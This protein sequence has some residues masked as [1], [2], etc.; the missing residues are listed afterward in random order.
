MK[1]LRVD[2]SGFDGERHGG[3]MTGIQVQFDDSETDFHLAKAKALGYIVQELCR[4]GL[5]EALNGIGILDEYGKRMRQEAEAAQR[6]AFDTLPDD[7]EA[8]H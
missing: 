7:Y 6:R 3:S 1:Y 2:V 4:Y 8:P 5:H